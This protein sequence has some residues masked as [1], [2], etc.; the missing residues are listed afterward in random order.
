MSLACSQDFSKISRRVEICSVVL[1]PR[2]KPHWVS[3][4]FGS[5]IFAASWHALFLGGLAKRCR[6]SWFIHSCLHF[7]VWDDQ[8][9]NISAHFQND[10]PLDSHESAKPSSVPSF[11]NSLTNFSQLALSSDLAAASESLLMHSST[12]DFTSAKS[13]HPAWRT[14][15]SSARW[16]GNM[17]TK[18]KHYVEIF[19]F[20]KSQ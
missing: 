20:Y 5:I 15:L 1:R 11:P 19:C 4:I 8:F 12:E 7:C 9:A 13:K 10:M 14:L 16:S 2:Q 6:G 17:L 3:F 18:G